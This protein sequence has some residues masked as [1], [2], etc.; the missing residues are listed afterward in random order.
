MNITEEDVEK[1]LHYLATSAHD[2]AYWKGQVTVKEYAI[3]IKESIEFLGVESGTQE[4]KKSKARSSI[5]YKKATEE[6]EEA[7]V[8]F[9]EINSLRRAAEMK[10][11]VYQSNVK[12]YQQGLHI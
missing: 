3:K 2:H 11:S 12:A 6:Y 4:Y 1:A 7:I 5:S 10:I 8:K 9:T